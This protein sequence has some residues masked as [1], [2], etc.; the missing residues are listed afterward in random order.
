MVNID[1][2]PS[3]P[4]DLER[5]TQISRQS[6]DCNFTSTQL[7]V[8]NAKQNL[9]SI[10]F[11][12]LLAGF[13]AQSVVLD[14]AELLQLTISTDQRKKGLAKAALSNWFNCLSDQGVNQ[15]FLEVR[16]QNTA[17]IS[18]Y[19][20][21]GFTQVGIRKGYYLIEGDTQNALVMSKTL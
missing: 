3:V 20:W 15:V 5:L 6:T 14:E 11:D 19:H 13:I 16:E 4:N 8:L 7:A 10:E 1:V 2:R 21:F 17:A 18:L 9:F 12:G